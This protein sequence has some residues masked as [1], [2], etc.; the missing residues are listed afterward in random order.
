MEKVAFNPNSV[1]FNQDPFAVMGYFRE[2]DPIHFFELNRF[3]RTLRCWLI[4]GY[5]DCNTFIK[6]ERITRDVK[7]VMSPEMIKA[8]NVSEDVNFVSD[9]MLFK[10]APDH[11]RLRSLVHLAFTPRTIENMRASITQTAERLLDEMEKKVEVDIMR[12]FASPLPF[13]VLSELMGIPEE[14]R[15]TFNVWTNTIVDTSEANQ[16]LSNKYI[17]EFKSYLGKLIEDRKANPKD[18]LISKLVQ[19][20]ENGDRL[21]EAELYAMLFILVVAGLETTVNLLG[22]GTLALLQHRDQLE[23]LKQHPEMIE[24]AVEELLRYTSP[25]MMMANRWALE[26]FS[27]EGHSFQKGDMFFIG[28][29]A[30]NRDP[31]QFENPDQLDLDRAPNRHIAFGNGIHVCL[32]APLARMEGQ[33]AFSALLKRFPDIQLKVTA[34]ELKWRKNAF[35]RGLEE[36]PVSL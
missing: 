10:D 20:E 8:I 34:D 7:K 3:G 19:A 12:D 35:L 29:G 15:E 2:N 33:I 13:I 25:V 28:V 30:A 24:S 16:E 18:D 6:E 4:T 23:A 31:K 22:S 26:D 14:D 5:D 32:G 9:H 17:R 21:D 36:L 27:Y 11:T 1:E